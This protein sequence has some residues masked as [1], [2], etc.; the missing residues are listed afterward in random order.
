MPPRDE[1]TWSGLEPE[2][3]ILNERT[4][5]LHFRALQVGKEA[6]ALANHLQEPLPTVMILR[7]SAEVTGQ[8]PNPLRQ[9]RNLHTR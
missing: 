2:P 4:I 7:M 5:V 9:Q 1:V 6:L 8:M 3:K